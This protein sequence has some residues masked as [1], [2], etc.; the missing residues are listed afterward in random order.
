MKK[1]ALL[2]AVASLTFVAST[3]GA[4]V[5]QFD[6]NSTVNDASTATGVSSPFIGAGTISTI[7]SVG[8]PGFNSGVGSSDTN[9]TDNSGYQTDTYPAQSTANQTA[10]IQVAASTVGFQDISINFDLRTSNTSSRWFQVQIST[11]GTSFSNF[12]TPVRLGGVAPSA[13]DLWSNSNTADLSA[14]TSVDDNPNFAFRV[15]SSFSPVAFTQI[16]GSIA[17][18]A[19]TAYEVARNPVTGANSAYVGGTWR[20][21]MV[22]INGDVIPEPTV[23]G[24]IA[25]GSLAMLRRRRA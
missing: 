2:A 16:N 15:V 7:G 4:V 3:Q 6:F 11:D 10:G 25:A 8:N 5:T 19:D 13:G 18:G 9:A 1:F 23:L 14:L 21:D 22:T 12:G 20:F 17:Y 24:L